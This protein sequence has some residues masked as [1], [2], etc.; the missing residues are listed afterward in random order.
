MAKSW[1]NW[2]HGDVVVVPRYGDIVIFNRTSNP[3]FGHVAFFERWDDKYIYVIGGN[4]G[5]MVKS[6]PYLRSRLQGFRRPKPKNTGKPVVPD[7]S[8]V[9]KPVITAPEAVTG[10]GG[11]VVATKP[12]M[13]GDWL[14]GVLVLLTFAAVAGYFI[15]QRHTKARRS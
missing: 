11:A 1:L 2:K 10:A 4:Q 5:D 9:K 6:S 3:A 8:Q 14:V 12:F 13:D 7:I 15:W